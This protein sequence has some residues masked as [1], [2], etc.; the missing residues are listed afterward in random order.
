MRVDVGQHVVLVAALTESDR[1]LIKFVANKMP[2][3]HGTSERLDDL[4]KRA[5]KLLKKLGG[6]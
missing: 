4:T 6:P 3:G 2:S 5:N 1:E